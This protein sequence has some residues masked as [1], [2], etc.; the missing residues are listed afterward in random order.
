[1]ANQR[2][3]QAYTSLNNQYQAFNN[4]ATYPDYFS[5]QTTPQP[6]IANSIEFTDLTRI[7]AEDTHRRRRRSTTAQDK[8]AATNMRIVSQ[9]IFFRV[10]RYNLH[11]RPFRGGG[12]AQLSMQGA[13]ANP[14][15]SVAEPR[16][17]RL[18]GL[19]ESARKNTSNT[20]STSWNCWRPN[21]RASKN[22]IP[23]SMAR[24]RGY[25][26]RSSS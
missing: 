11:G 2:S 9:P 26:M 25:N 10:L 13:E 14:A 3:S 20:S 21:T 7:Q 5:Q 24:M 15:Y 23:R 12:F 22:R 16:T 6:I 4:G 19:S 18:K 17:E 1:M 8:E